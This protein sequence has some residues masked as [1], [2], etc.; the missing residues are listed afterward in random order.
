MFHIPKQ[1]SSA[2]QA[3]APQVA[4]NVGLPVPGSPLELR[5]GAIRNLACT[6]NEEVGE[7]RDKLSPVLAPQAPSKP[8]A[9]SSEPQGSTPAPL[10]MMLG[11]IEDSLRCLK[12]ELHMIRCR[13]CC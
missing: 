5:V 10:I 9:V 3:Y 8:E 13:A 1:S 4:A 11:E 7:L 2:D 6:L 12:D